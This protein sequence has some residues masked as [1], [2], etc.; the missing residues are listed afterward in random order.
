MI[1]GG[2][3]GGFASGCWHTTE[4]ACIELFV[5]VLLGMVL[6]L[7]VLAVA[8]SAGRLILW[9]VVLLLVE[10]RVIEAI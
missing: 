9:L 10:L 2:H 4:P 8:V 3:C 6:G 1:T 5:G 7:R